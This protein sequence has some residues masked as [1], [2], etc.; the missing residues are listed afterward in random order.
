MPCLCC[1]IETH[2]TRDCTSSRAQIVDQVVSHW[3][4]HRLQQI[5]ATED[6]NSVHWLATSNQLVHLSKGDLLYLLRDIIVD[7]PGY[8]NERLIYMYLHFIVWS[9]YQAYHRDYSAKVQ[10]RISADIRFWYNLSNSICSVNEAEEIRF[11]ELK[12][13]YELMKLPNTSECIQCAVCLNEEITKKNT[14][15]YNCAHSFCLICSQ[16]LL[17]REILKCP[18]CRGSIE[19]VYEFIL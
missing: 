11:I 5:Y 8:I 2:D 18:L 16:T 10:K 6:S 1:H 14:H 15:Q 19:T 13:P 3:I 7:D 12:P 9:F 17:E 4:F